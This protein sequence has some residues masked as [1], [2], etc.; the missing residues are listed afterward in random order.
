MFGFRSARLLDNQPVDHPNDSH[1]HKDSGKFRKRTGRRTQS[2]RATLNRLIGERL[3]ERRVLAAYVVDTALDVVAEDGMISLR[4]AIQASNSN[5]AVNSDTVAGEPAAT[6]ID[7]ITFAD[8]LSMIL[9][10]SEL[11]ITESLRISLGDSSGQIIS[12]DNASRI[13]AINASGGDAVSVDVSGLTLQDGVAESGGAIYVGA[14]Q[15]LSLTNVTLTGNMAT[16]D[17][18][19]MGGGA[20]AIDGGNVTITDSTITENVAD[21]V[22]GSGG[23]ILNQGT[24]TVSGG[25]ISDNT[26][27]RAG[28]GIEATAGSSTTLTDVLMELNVAGPDGSAAPGNGGALHISGDG[29][30]DISGGTIRDNM[31]AREGGGLWNNTGAMT[32]DGTI[33]TGNIA[34]GDAAD[35][36]GGAI[37][38]N[39]GTLTV[40]NAIISGNAADGVLGSGGGIFSTDGAVT[41]S[42][43]QIGGAIPSEGNTANRAGGGI[44]VIDGT[45]T[46]NFVGS[47]V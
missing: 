44:E 47:E 13:F 31:A 5:A 19:D 43:T 10:G 23:G 24:L 18:A 35:D 20:L 3:E 29:N 34:S 8:G 26:A 12:G 37:F 16:G 2:R 45:V 21:G 42:S 38:N 17:D 11:E 32:V 15:S 1:E 39:G 4:E 27:N 14:G 30:A 46:L 9:L 6:A 41:I 36:G 33:L 7:S 22:S 28:G 40:S 25:E